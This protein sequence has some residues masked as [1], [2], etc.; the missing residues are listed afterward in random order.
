M[1]LHYKIPVLL[2]EFDKDKAFSLHAD[3]DLR[4]E[5]DAKD[6]GSRLCLL[7]LHFPK[8]K[9]LWSSNAAATA[10][11]FEDL[12]VCRRQGIRVLAVLLRFCTEKSRG[13][14]YGGGDGGRS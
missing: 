2:I 10:E 6:V 12:K 4:G 1:S 14:E 7:C 9:I 5:I 8:L 13:T 3:R 11:I